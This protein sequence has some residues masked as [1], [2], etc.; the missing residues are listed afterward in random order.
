MYTFVLK[1]YV[2]YNINEFINILSGEIIMYGATIKH[3]EDSLAFMRGLTFIGGFL[4]AYSFFTRGGAFVSFHT[5]NLVRIGLAVVLNDNFQL[6]NSLTPVI[7]AFIG[8]VTAT[9][10]RNKITK[11]TLFNK[12]IVLTE[13]AVLF[14]IGFIGT[15]SIDYIINFTLSFIAMFQLSCFRKAKNVVHN[16][17]IMTG[18][19]RTLAQLFTNMF[20]ERNKK[21]VM[22]FFTYLITFLSFIF[23]VIIGGFSSLRFEK[24]SIWICAAILL[25]LFIKMDKTD[26]QIKK[27]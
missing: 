21:N 11:D 5:G 2:S 26:T 23:G 8:V 13:I 18:N 27:F 25:I 15:N 7:G 20:F 12:A 4:N 14:I 6:W 3:P 16:T 17:T 22:E 10:I 1:F 9:I 19:L 24:M